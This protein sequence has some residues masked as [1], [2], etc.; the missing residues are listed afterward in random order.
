MHKD[1][2]NPP[3]SHLWSTQHSVGCTDHP[4]KCQFI[5]LN[6][7]CHVSIMFQNV[8]DRFIA[9]IVACGCKRCVLYQHMMIKEISF[10]HLCTQM[11][12]HEGGP[13]NFVIN[14]N[15][16]SSIIFSPSSSPF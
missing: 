13:C 9:P 8:V 3:I 4:K 6:D 2:E 7:T 12:V 5:D 16:P 1:A 14:C 10:A 11:H 15:T